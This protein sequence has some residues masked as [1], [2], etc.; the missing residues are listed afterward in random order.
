MKGATM[1]EA[2]WLTP[3]GMI[4]IISLAIAAYKA[5]SAWLRQQTTKAEAE[6]K[7][8]MV[9]RGMTAEQIERV[10]AA[11]MS[12]DRATDETQVYAKT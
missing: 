8:E 5:I 11:S 9:S 1:W 4:A 6:L 12:S 2:M 10:L 7:L 3:Y